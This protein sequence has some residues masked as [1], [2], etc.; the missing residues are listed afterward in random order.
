M[1]T[2]VE[3]EG[4]IA[5]LEFVKSHTAKCRR[6][7]GIKRYDVLKRKTCAC[8]YYANG[9]LDQ[10][11]G[12]KRTPTGE[13][14]LAKAQD[15]IRKRIQTGNPKASLA[16]NAVTIEAATKDYL[17]TVVSKDR[18]DST[19]KK[20]TTLMDQLVA[21]CKNKGYASIKSFDQDA[22]QAFYDAWADPKA[23]YKEDTKWTKM[24]NGTRKRS[25]KTMSLFFERCMR[26]KWITEDPTLIIEVTAESRKKTREQVKYLTRE[27]MKKVVDALDENYHQMSDYNK[28]R[29]KAL[30]LL[31]RWTGLRI[32]DAVKVKIEDIKG[33]VLLVV[34]KK[35]KAPVQLPI[36]VE[37]LEMIQK[38][39]PYDGGYLFWNRRSE[40]S[41]ITTVEH[42]FGTAISKLFEKAGV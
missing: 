18:T 8:P 33:D 30:M 36:P 16:P 1:L 17:A 19:S 4:Q 13:I 37:A 7:N 9:V 11:V 23:A 2:S 35:T 24:S 39:A 22:M 28:T 34:T 12:F 25:L 3:I 6:E 15:V 38:L 31:M 20:Y 40:K 21:F 42:N 26:R 41:S 14:T 27:Q 10:A 29:L 32:S 5:R